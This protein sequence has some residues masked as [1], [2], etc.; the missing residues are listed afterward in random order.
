[1][2]FYYTEAMHQYLHVKYLKPLAGRAAAVITPSCSAGVG[3]RLRPLT[4]RA[5]RICRHLRLTPSA[6]H[7]ERASAPRGARC[8]ALRTRCTSKRL[9]PKARS[10]D[11]AP[12]PA[13]P[14]THKPPPRAPRGR[15]PTAGYRRRL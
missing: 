8:V 1:M 11:L 4:A 2:K 5:G 14:A 9:P 3:G 13:P 12:P 7:C 6:Y 15:S 10:S